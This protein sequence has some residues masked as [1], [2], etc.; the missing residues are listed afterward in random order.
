M[1]TTGEGGNTS[2]RVGACTPRAPALSAP[3]PL[4]MT[5]PRYTRAKLFAE[6]GKQTEMLAR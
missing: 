5:S 3:S 6:V 4:R 1:K 2:K